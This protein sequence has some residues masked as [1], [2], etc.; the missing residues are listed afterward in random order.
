MLLFTAP[1]PEAPAIE[2]VFLCLVNVDLPVA[3]G[4]AAALVLKAP[5]LTSSSLP[6]YVPGCRFMFFIKADCLVG[7][8]ASLSLDF[9]RF[10]IPI[11]IF[12]CSVSLKSSLSI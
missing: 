7:G 5:A 2:L 1:I 4:L 3:P 6:P 11:S 10:A 9:G 12:Y 8:R